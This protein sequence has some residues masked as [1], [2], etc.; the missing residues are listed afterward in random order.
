MWKT[1]Q[2][3][4]IQDTIDE[5]KERIYFPNTLSYWGERYRLYMNQTK[6]H[7]ENMEYSNQLRFA[8]NFM[9]KILNV[10]TK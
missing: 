6:W 10:V 2:N 4:I 7:Y 3:K 1:W 9:A 5:N 8:L